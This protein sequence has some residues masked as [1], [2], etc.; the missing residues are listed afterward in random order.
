MSSRSPVCIGVFFIWHVSCSGCLYWKPIYTGNELPEILSVEPPMDQAV[1]LDRDRIRFTVIS[2]DPEE[3]PLGFFWQLPVFAE[4]VEDHSDGGGAFFNT[5]DLNVGP[6]LD[7]EE[8][9]FIITDIGEDDP[10][11][12]S[13]TTS[14]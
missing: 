1:L 12:L 14:K 7:G 9:S 5:F 6:G 2:T 4:G 10:V 13:L 8:L 3:A 11:T